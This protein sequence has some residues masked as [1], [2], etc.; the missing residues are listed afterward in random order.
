[1][2]TILAHFK[3]LTPYIVI[4]NSFYDF[5]V[6]IIPT[7][8]SPSGFLMSAKIP[9]LPY[10]NLSSNLHPC[11]CRSIF[12]RPLQPYPS[13]VMTVSL[14]SC[15]TNGNVYDPRE[16][17]GLEFR[18]GRILELL[19]LAKLFNPPETILTNPD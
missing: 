11:L 2:F 14:S 13:T 15:D 3:P 1:M 8:D 17:R 19:L 5:H 12:F 6:F 10:R 9:V 7:Q 4:Y 16:L 18:Q